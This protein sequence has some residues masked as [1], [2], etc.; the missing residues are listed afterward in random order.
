MQQT[1]LLCPAP[2]EY[3]HHKIDGFLQLN[4]IDTQIF[5][6]VKLPIAFNAAVD[7]H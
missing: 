5:E 2:P 4:K 1:N 7:V 6:V 3:R